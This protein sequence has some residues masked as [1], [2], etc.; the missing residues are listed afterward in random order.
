M[1]ASAT[2]STQIIE[3][4]DGTPIHAWIYPAL[5][6]TAADGP[7]PAIVMAHG[8]GGIKSAGL[9]PFAEAFS[10][11][12]Y[13]CVVFDYRHW[14]ESG[15]EPREMLSMAAQQ[16]DYRTVLQH[17][18]T[19]DGV[20]PDRIVLWGTSFAGM[21][22]V[23]LA[24]TEDYLV[25]AVAQC[26]LV[27]GLAGI[28]NVPPARGLRLMRAAL[29]DRIG[30]RRGRDPR[31]LPLIV[32]EGE[33]GVIATKD[34]LL[35]QDRLAPTDGTE[36]PNRITARSL[37]EVTFSRPAR[38]ASKARCPVLMVVAEDDTMAPTAPAVKVAAKAPRGELYRSRGG[39]YDLYAGGPAHEDVVAVELAFLARVTA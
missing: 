12:G 6:R 30:A 14:G 27:D 21:H 2:R 25:G 36:W 39:H 38:R 1:A 37:L 23:E 34:A 5:G 10:A 20:D 22:V 17:A 7:A 28:L 8:I 24:A 31:Y 26:P 18:R 4:V 15:G 33:H 11:A 9:A 32:G 29:L 13:T 19:I 16:A 35:G 3:G